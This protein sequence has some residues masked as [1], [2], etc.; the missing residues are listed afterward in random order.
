MTKIKHTYI[1]VNHLFILNTATASIKDYEYVL[2]WQCQ[3]V[4]GIL[5]QLRPY[6]EYRQ[7]FSRNELVFQHELFEKMSKD[8]NNKILEIISI[9]I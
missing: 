8:V 9:S 2:N 3:N 7:S 5:N 6:L 4:E 1:Q